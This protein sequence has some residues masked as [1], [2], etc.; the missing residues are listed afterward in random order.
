MT[1]FKFDEYFYPALNACQ[2]LTDISC[3]RKF[4][5]AI[6]KSLTLEQFDRYNELLD[7]K[8]KEFE[9]ETDR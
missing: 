3:M 7:K 1:E 2:N 6:N 5:E 4:V 8:A 9:K